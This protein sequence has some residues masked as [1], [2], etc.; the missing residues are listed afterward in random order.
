MSGAFARSLCRLAQNAQKWTLQIS[1]ENRVARD[2]LEAAR[3]R[4]FGALPTGTKRTG[5]KFLRKKLAGPTLTKWYYRGLKVKSLKQ[6][7]DGYAD[8]KWIYRQFKL[9]ELR[10]RGK[11]PPK[12]GEGKRAKK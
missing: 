3:F 11:G 5:N 7:T 8:P 1:E 9:A 12:K 10:R 2:A 4:L 6:F